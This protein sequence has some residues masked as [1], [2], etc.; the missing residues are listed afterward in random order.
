M[1]VVTITN[2]ELIICLFPVGFRTCHLLLL[3]LLQ[4]LLSWT[5]G[6]EWSMRA[7]PDV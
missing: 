7:S 4:I 5:A 3:E 2:A 1:G 6:G